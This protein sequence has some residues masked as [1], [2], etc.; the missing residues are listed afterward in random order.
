[1]PP[2]QEPV[3]RFL[4][5][6]AARSAGRIEEARA[7]FAGLMPG[8]QD[9]M[10]KLLLATMLPPVYSSL[11]DLRDRRDRALAELSR[12]KQSGFCL[13]LSGV[14][15]VP[16]MEITYQGLNDR[17]AQRLLAGLQRAPQ[18]PPLPSLHRGG[19]HDRIRLGLISKYFRDHTI[20]KLMRGLIA[21]LSRDGFLVTVFTFGQATDPIANFCRDHADICVPL[22]DDPA[23]S[24]AAILGQKLDVLYYT[25]IGMEPATFTLAQSR[26]APV[27]CVTWGHPDTTGIDTVDYFISSEALDTD[28]AQE[29]YAEKLIRLNHPAIYYYRPPTVGPLPGRRELGLPETGTLYGCLQT[30]TKFHPEFDQLLADILRRDVTATLLLLTGNF[31]DMTRA[32]ADRFKST[33]PDVGN[34]VRFLPRMDLP[35]FLS[36]Q[37]AL[38]VSLD[39][40]HFGGGNTSYEALAQGTPIVTLPAPFLRGRITYALYKEMGVMDCVAADFQGYVDLA[41][42][43]GMDRQF[44]QAVRDKILATNAVLYEN[45]AG[46]RDLE[47]FLRTV[48]PRC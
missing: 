18:Q 34:R 44:R 38:D 28:L 15:G 14:F 5:G 13:D 27:Q 4:M 11:N 37:A 24:R 1:M 19:G 29:H 7:I 25:D 43:L 2:S 36:V 12:M 6:L 20:G 22:P 16:W 31:P 46:L 42:R 32:L 21:K 17:D 30:L 47:G 40:I 9:A 41:V 26:L 10:I 33:M 23:A 45:P 39:P 48:S 35:K 8:P 3:R